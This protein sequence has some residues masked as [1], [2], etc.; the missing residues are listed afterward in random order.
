MEDK[1]P[2]LKY[3]NYHVVNAPVDHIYVVTDKGLYRKPYVI[4]NDRW[5]RDVKK[6][7]AFHKDI[8]HNIESC[9][10]IKDEIERLIKAGYFKEFLEEEPQIANRNK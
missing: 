1:A 9:I 7:C 6:N 8:G 5:R 10:A 3:T 4:R 2:L